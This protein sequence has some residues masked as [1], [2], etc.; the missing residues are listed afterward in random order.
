[1]ELELELSLQIPTRLSYWVC[2]KSDGQRVLILILVNQMT[3]VQEV[4]LIDRKNDYRQVNNLRFPHHAKEEMRNHTLLDGE[5]VLDRDPRTG[6]VSFG[7]ERS[8]ERSLC[9]G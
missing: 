8:R 5:L 2:E 1:M 3:K 4:F 7:F 6:S 9:H